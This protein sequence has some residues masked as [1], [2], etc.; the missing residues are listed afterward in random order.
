MN[1]PAPPA[2]SQGQSQE[3][4]IEP[5]TRR[6]QEI[7]AMVGLALT[8]SQIANVLFISTAAV[9]FHILNIRSKLNLP[10]RTHLCR[11]VLVSHYEKKTSIFDSVL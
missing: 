10:S 2:Q 9:R 1:V 11:W 4:L 3:Q 5:L 6:E 7:A 8:D